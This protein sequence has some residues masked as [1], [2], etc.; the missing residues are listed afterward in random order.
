MGSTNTLT[1]AVWPGPVMPSATAASATTRQ[2]ENRVRVRGGTGVSSTE[3]RRSV[4]AD[5]LAGQPLVQLGAV[6]GE[7][8]D[9]GLDAARG[10]PRDDRVE[11]RDG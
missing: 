1:P 10:E 11:G 3:G 9:A 4:A 2:P 7:A 8:D 5:E 6:V